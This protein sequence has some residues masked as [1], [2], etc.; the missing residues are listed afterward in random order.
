MSGFYIMLYCISIASVKN[1]SQP[2]FILDR[3]YVEE[4]K[5][6][7]WGAFL[8]LAFSKFNDLSLILNNYC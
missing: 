5:I 1:V 3:L 4:D 7:E 2:T 6:E 8:L